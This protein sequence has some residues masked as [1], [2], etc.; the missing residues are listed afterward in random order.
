MSS[1]LKQRLTEYLW[2]N[3]PVPRQPTVSGV[4]SPRQ[5]PSLV[6]SGTV[7]DSDLRD[8]RRTSCPLSPHE[9]D[10]LLKAQRSPREVLDYRVDQGGAA[11]FCQHWGMLL[12]A[13]GAADHDDR[14]GSMPGRAAGEWPA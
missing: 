2:M 3:T 8:H 14:L 4:R 5:A 13:E 1:P 6:T 7:L 9:F 10:G 11:E 12:P